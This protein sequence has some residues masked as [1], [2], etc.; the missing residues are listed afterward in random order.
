MSLAAL[1]FA[2]QC[3][4]LFST[5]FFFFTVSTWVIRLK[6]L[7]NKSKVIR[8]SSAVKIRWNRRNAFR[9]WQKSV[10]CNQFLLISRTNRGK[11]S[12]NVPDGLRLWAGGIGWWQPADSRVQRMCFV[13]YSEFYGNY[14]LK[15]VAKTKETAEETAKTVLH[16][17]FWPTNMNVYRT[18]LTLTP[19]RSGDAAHS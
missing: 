13:E 17:L 12:E 16:K 15:L 14:P 7:L 18:T 2:A 9:K 10:L 1:T 3:C 5:S 8:R 6:K 19:T 11:L 4:Q